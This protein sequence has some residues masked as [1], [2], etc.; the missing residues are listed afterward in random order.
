MAATY[1]P[2][3]LVALLPPQT[4]ILPSWLAFISLV[5]AG[6]SLQTF[7]TLKAT[8]EI[9]GND[10]AQVTWLHSHTF[11]TWTFLSAAIRAYCA[12]NPGNK[13]LY[14]LC[15][16]SYWLAFAHFGSE[17]LYFG[18]AKFGRG[19]IGPLVVSTASIVWMT[20]QRGYY[21]GL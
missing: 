20:M 14:D 16:L 2:D 9:F 11:G 1:L 13:E 3:S 5:A 6:N 4:G 21:L 8:K 19:L 10:P 12:Y 18:T 7:A 15:L 17:W